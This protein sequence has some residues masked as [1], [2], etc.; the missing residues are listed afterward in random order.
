M[1]GRWRRRFGAVL[2]VVALGAVVLSGCGDDDDEEGASPS[3]SASEAPADDGEGEGGDTIA[4]TASD[5]KFDT[6]DTLE[7]GIVTVEFANEGEKPHEMGLAK[8]AEE[9]DAEGFGELL[10]PVFEGGP[11]PDDFQGHTG[12]TETEPGDTYTSTFTLEPGTYALYCSISDEQEDDD[13]EAAEGEEGA[14]EE[15]APP[16]FM[17]GMYETLEIEGEAGDAADLPSDHV[18]TATDYTFEIPELEAGEQELTFVNGSDEQWHH[19]V[20]FV[21]PEGVDE[22]EADKAWQAT[23]TLEEG[24]APPEGTP[25]PEDFAGSQV[26]SPH[27]GGTFPADITAGRT[28]TAVCFIQDQAGGPPHAFAHD[29]VK[30]FTVS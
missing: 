29:M 25:E 26:F 11:F 20:L 22:A 3:A 27:G 12:I 16:H 2:A 5:Y 21:W 8:L 13:E 18:I 7:A 17:L 30:H 15:E 9:L 28:Y 6:D 19:V 23:A 14:A 24:E 10:G 1:Q 4:I